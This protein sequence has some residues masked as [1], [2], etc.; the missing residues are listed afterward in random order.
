MINKELVEREVKRIEKARLERKILEAQKKKGIYNLKALKNVDTLLDDEELPSF[1]HS[2]ER[3]F[4][5]DTI[6][7]FN[8][9]QIMKTETKS[10][11]FKTFR[12]TRTSFGEPLLNI[13]V[14]IDD[15]NTVEKLEIFANDDPVMVAKNFC[16]KYG[17]SFLKIRTRRR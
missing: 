11:F 1:N 16:E 7:S 6:D 13:E 12:N 8:R 17:N 3:K 9:S 10:D 2:I 14:N 15:K 5:K 4:H